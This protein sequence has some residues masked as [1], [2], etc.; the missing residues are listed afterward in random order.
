M[1]AVY[2]TGYRAGEIAHRGSPL[3]E[4]RQLATGQAVA[5]LSAM[6]I[7]K[8]TGPDAGRW[9]HSITTQY[10]DG[11]PAGTSTETLVLSPTGHI[12]HWAY[13]YVDAHGAYWL[14]VD[15]P[16]DGLMGFLKSMV[17]MMRVDIAEVAAPVVGSVNLESGQGGA[18]V[19]VLPGELFQWN[20]PWPAVAPGSATYAAVDQDA[21]PGNHLDF[22]LHVLGSHAGALDTGALLRAVEAEIPVVG[23]DAWE[24]LCI[25]AWRPSIADCD[26]KTLVGEID[27]LRTAVHLSKGCYRGQEAVA[28]VHNLGQVPRRLV[29][30]HLDGSDHALARQG[31]PILGPVRGNERQVGEVTSA[32]VHY[33]LG[34]IALGLI[35]RTVTPDATLTVMAEDGNTRVAAAQELIVAT[36]KETTRQVLP[37]NPVFRPDLKR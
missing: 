25:E 22:R 23:R 36:S 34:P 6:S 2:G 20:D 10:L 37:R 31:D 4:Q 17:F 27:I 11:L 29:F 14:I 8:V 33:E 15:A 9:L 1:N 35:K 24:A 7:I 12:E 21:H 28:R 5:D 26:Y 30:L 18:R 13:V 3:R 19:P 32:A 16:T